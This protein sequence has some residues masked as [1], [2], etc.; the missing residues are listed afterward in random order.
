MS[1]RVSST[2]VFHMMRVQA[3][4]LI[5]ISYEFLSLIII[6][7]IIIIIVPGPCRSRSPSCR[8]P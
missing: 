7:I 5:E 4:E 2:E 3:E 8:C 1:Y 6:I